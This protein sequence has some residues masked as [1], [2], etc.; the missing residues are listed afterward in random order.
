MVKNE[1]FRVKK[2][3]DQ[4]TMYQYHTNIAKHYFCSKCKIYTHHNPRSAPHMT[5]INLGCIDDIDTTKLKDVAFF[6]GINHPLDQ[7]NKLNEIS[8]RLLC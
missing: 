8:R 4:L 1:D 2:G 3:E 6:D 5:G 7:R